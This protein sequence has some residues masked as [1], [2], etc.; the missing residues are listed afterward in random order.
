[1]ILG[2]F[3][4]RAVPPAHPGAHEWVEASEVEEPGQEP[5]ERSP[6]MTSVEGDAG[7]DEAKGEINVTGWALLKEFD[8]WA[9]FLFNGLCSG[10]GLSE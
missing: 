2:T 10:T 8:F 6:L 9:I 3:F 5:D 7:K 1:M 4:I